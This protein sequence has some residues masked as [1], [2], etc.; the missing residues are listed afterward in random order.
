MAKYGPFPYS[1]MFERPALT[2]PNGAHVAVWI[3]PNIEFFA[4]DAN[5]PPSAGGTGAPAPDVPTWSL[6]DYGNRVGVFRLMDVMAK[7]NVRATV[8][9]NSDVCEQHPQ[10]LTRGNA[11]GWEWMGHNRTNTERLNAVPADQEAV[12]IRD[13]LQTI[14]AATGTR[15]RGWLGAGLQETFKTPDLLA[16][17]GLD[18]VADWVNDDQPYL[19]QLEAG[20]NLVSMPYSYD[21]NDKPV[22]EYLHWTPAQ[23]VKLIRRQFDTLY[24]EGA[25]SGRVMAIALHPYLSGAPHRIEAVDK[26][27]AYIA[28]HKHVWFATG[29]EIAAEYRRQTGA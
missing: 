16:A 25:E 3:I 12:I 17:A 29:A 13:S 21:V 15:P 26:A 20:R 11:L 2:W 9:L 1:P 28:R 4:L 8:A 24:R 27:L 10:I 18:Y 22:Y 5:V 19:M 23:F 6:R 14:E 7:H